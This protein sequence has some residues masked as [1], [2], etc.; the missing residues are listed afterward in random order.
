ML[1]T[2]SLYELIISLVMGIFTILITAI[3]TEKIFFKENVRPRLIKGNTAVGLFFG[4]AI[5]GVL[6]NVN[7]SIEPAVNLLQTK[8]MSAGGF[9][10]SVLFSSILQFLFFYFVAF[11]ISF[12]MYALC[13]GVLILLTK[14]FD[15]V[16]LIKEGNMSVSAMFSLILV[17]FCLFVSPATKHFIGSLVNYNLVQSE[18]QKTR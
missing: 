7:G 6:I 10:I 8:L 4:A 9:R 15:E 1:I 17:G 13:F 2:L 18:I 5:L 14:G 16:G 3:F 11:T 12:L